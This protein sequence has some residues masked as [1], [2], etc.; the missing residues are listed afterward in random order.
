ME[1]SFK[2]HPDDYCDSQ[3][4]ALWMYDEGYRYATE[5]WMK[6]IG[7][8]PHSPFVNQMIEEIREIRKEEYEMEN[9]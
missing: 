7:I 8:H 9:E 3:D 4:C 6:A 1:I 2:N 5:Y